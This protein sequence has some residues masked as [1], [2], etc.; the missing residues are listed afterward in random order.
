MFKALCENTRGKLI[1]S[2]DGPGSSSRSR[3]GSPACVKHTEIPPL[4]DPTTRGIAV[5]RLECMTPVSEIM[6]RGVQI[7]RPGAPAATARE[8]MRRRGIHHLLVKEDRELVGVLSV[9]DLKRGAKRGNEPRRTV[10]ADF[11][12]PTI[13]AVGPETSVH[14]AANLMRGHSIGC[15][16]VVDAG[17][18][19]GIVT[20]AD[21]LDQAGEPRR[22]R[23][24]RRPALHYRVPH[25]KQHRAGASW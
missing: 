12:T 9:R 23:G 7:I 24:G 18:A 16:I 4:F 5:A 6:T 14:K 8:H 19:I 25:R 3:P 2:R 20:L 22:H 1:F 13:V 15:L 17:E 11:M 10:V 21:L